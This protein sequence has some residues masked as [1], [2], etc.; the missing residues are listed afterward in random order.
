MSLKNAFKENIIK[1]DSF[2]NTNTVLAIFQ[3]LATASIGVYTIYAGDQTDIARWSS[4]TFWIFQTIV[5]FYFLSM[6]LISEKYRTIKLRLNRTTGVLYDRTTYFRNVSIRDETFNIILDG[7]GG[8]KKA[9]TIGK[10]TGE[11]FH[12]ALEGVLH[13][14]GKNYNA[15]DQLKKWLEYDSSSGMGK[16]EVLQASPS[17]KFKITSPFV[18]TCPNQNPNPRCGFLLGYVE[19]FCSKLYEKDFNIECEH[20]P[21]PAFCIVTLEPV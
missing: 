17:I 6:L 1:I 20:N 7:I 21:N 10:K 8:Y 16:F 19:G 13:R 11:N 12:S 4:Y 3:V 9:H 5:L 14:K 15:E 2:E 18:G